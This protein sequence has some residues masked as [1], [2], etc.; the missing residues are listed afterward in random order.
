MEL[1]DCAWFLKGVRKKKKFGTRWFDKQNTDFR[2]QI[3][4]AKVHTYT[5]SLE[6]QFL[7]TQIMGVFDGH[8]RGVVP[9]SGNVAFFASGVH[10]NI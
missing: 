6:L 1:A 9:F 3:K 7:Q 8:S 2:Y 4:T 5:N 10:L